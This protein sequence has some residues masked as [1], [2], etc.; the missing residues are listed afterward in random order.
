MQLNVQCEFHELIKIIL[1]KIIFCTPRILY[2]FSNAISS[3]ILSL[4]WKALNINLEYNIIKYVSYKLL[5]KTILQKIIF[6][7]SAD[8]ILSFTYK[9]Y[10]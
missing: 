4:E 5:K 2:Y 9:K 6:F 8:L 7:K 1:P 3:I 10:W